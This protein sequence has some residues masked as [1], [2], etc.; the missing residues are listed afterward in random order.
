MKQLVTVTLFFFTSICVFAQPTIEIYLTN[1]PYPSKGSAIES[2]EETYELQIKEVPP[3]PFKITS[4]FDKNGY[5]LSETKY[6]N[7]GG[8]QSETK[9]EY[10]QNRNLTKKE[11]RYF[12]NMLGWKTD[13]VSLSYNDT[14]G[15]ISE[16]KFVNNGKTQT[17]SKVFCDNSGKP[18]EVRVLDANGA[19]SM[20]ERI[21][22]SPN[23]NI[24]RVMLIKPSGQ[25]SSLWLYPIDYTKP[26]QSRQVQRQYYP[27]G[28][29]MLESLEKQTKIDQGYYYE[30]RYDS[31]GNWVEKDTYQ[32]ALGKNNKIKD[33]KLEHKIRRTIKSY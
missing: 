9:W 11:H 8:K 20:I 28:E 18:N 5:I 27:N 17:V 19:F 12:A 6:G 10:N 30:Y 13:E 31:Q 24:I 22:Y 21:S 3:K 16:I 23:G 29:V 33:K 32:V 25:F 15:Y 4:S 1:H 2:I 7:T 26:Y 14:T